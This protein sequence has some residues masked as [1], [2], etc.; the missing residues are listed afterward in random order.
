MEL[1]PKL[2]VILPENP[3]AIP[4]HSILNGI[5]SSAYYITQNELYSEHE[6]N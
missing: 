2:L 5:Q 1:V 4:W 3:L 6:I